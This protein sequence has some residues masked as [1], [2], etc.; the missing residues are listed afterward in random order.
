MHDPVQ[1]R[2]M[3]WT[4]RLDVREARI[5]VFTHIRD[6]PYEIITGL[7]DPVKGPARTLSAGRGS[8]TAKHFLLGAMFAKMD[9]PVRYITFSFFWD[10]PDIDY[11]PKLRNLARQLPVEYHLAN[12]AFLEGK[13]VLVDATWDP[14]LAAAGYPVNERWDGV[15]DTLNAVKSLD[16]IAHESAVERVEFANKAEG[17]YTEDEKLARDE[18]VASLNSWLWELRGEDSEMW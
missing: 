10:D 8:C 1:E 5:A 12:K 2:L 4:R 13:W 11:P 9:I 14:P 7:K 6:M 16:E 15:S 17:A 18:F 3:Q